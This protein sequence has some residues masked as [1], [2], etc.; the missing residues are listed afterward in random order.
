M[1]R[2]AEIVLLPKVGHGFSVQRNWMPQLRE[3][4]ARIVPER[5]PTAA[6][7]AIPAGGE[8]SAAGEPS[9]S[10]LPV[11]EVPVTAGR[12]DTLAFIASGDGGW[13]SLDRQVAGV[14]TARG[15]PVVGLDTLQYYWQPRPPA[16]SARALERILRHYLE[17]WKKERILLVGYSRGAGVLPFMATRLPADLLDRVDLI[18]LLGP[19]R[20]ITFEFHYTDWIGSARGDTTPLQPEIEKLRGKTLLC[21]YGAEETDSVC[22]HLPAGL[23]RLDE[24]PGG[25]HFD[26]DY[27][28]IATRILA[29]AGR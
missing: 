6:Q 16:E 23:A 29:E 19:E 11:V 17:R 12:S 3:S 5:A 24:R 13:A 22:P 15:I 27:Q 26:G 7:S 18:A 14:F 1:I 9:V 4:F 10:D 20:D 2:G 25:H 28:A 8:S 21:V